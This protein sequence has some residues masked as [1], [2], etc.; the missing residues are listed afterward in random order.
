MSTE[1]TTFMN[2]EL[3]VNIRTTIINDEPYFVGKD[4]AEALG[5]KNTRDALNKHVDQED[6]TTRMLYHNA[7]KREYLTIFLNESGVKSLISRSRIPHKETVKLLECLGIE[8]S[9]VISIRPEHVALTTIEQ[10]L[11]I[12]LHRQYPV[13]D[14]RID[15]YDKENNVAY[16]IDEPQHFQ[17]IEDDKIRQ[18]YIEDKLGCKFIRIKV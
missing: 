1:I 13:D 9:V 12:K 11:G 17:S 4:V 14:Y 8:E 2:N 3:S 15:G 7:Q 18:K 5:Y 6:K 10:L 16:E